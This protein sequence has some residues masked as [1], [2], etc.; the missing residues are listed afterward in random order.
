MCDKLAPNRALVP[1]PT[2]IGARDSH[3]R[4]FRLS[5]K[6]QYYPIFSL[7]SS[8]SMFS[9]CCSLFVLDGSVNSDWN[10]GC[11]SVWEEDLSMNASISSIGT[12]Y[13]PRRPP[14]RNDL[15]RLDRRI[16]LKVISLTPKICDPSLRDTHL[17]LRSTITAAIFSFS[18]SR[19]DHG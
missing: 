16:R 3:S 11:I 5:S 10:R 13:A 9:V 19:V 4:L 14:I 2:A 8:V 1:R 7:G 6:N 12:R 15:I 17:L 18:S